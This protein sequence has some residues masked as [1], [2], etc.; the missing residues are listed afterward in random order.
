LKERAKLK[1]PPF[2][3]DAEEV[4]LEELEEYDDDPQVAE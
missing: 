1:A 3:F 2:D 4:E